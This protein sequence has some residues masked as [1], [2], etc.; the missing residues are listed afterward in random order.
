MG[1]LKDFMDMM[2]RGKEEDSEAGRAAEREASLNRQKEEDLARAQARSVS[3]PIKKE[4]RHSQ[5]E[6]RYILPEEVKKEVE[7]L[8]KAKREAARKKS[9]FGRFF[10]GKK[11]KKP[12]GTKNE[13]K[14]N[15]SSDADSAKNRDVKDIEAE[16]REKAEK[17][18]RLRG[19]ASSEKKRY[20]KETED[21][22]R[23]VNGIPDPERE[24]PAAETPEKDYGVV[25]QEPDFDEAD[26]DKADFDE[27]D[28]DEGDFDEADFNAAPS[29]TEPAAR[30]GERFSFMESV[31]RL[32][33]VREAGLQPSDFPPESPED[34]SQPLSSSQ[35]QET[36]QQPEYLPDP[37]DNPDY[38]RF[39]FA[40]FP[41][42][43]PD[44]VIASALSFAVGF[45][46]FDEENKPV[47]RIITIR[48]LFYQQGDILID[49]FCH[50]IAAPRLIP[51][52]QGIKMYNLQTMKP[53]DNPRDFLLHHMTGLEG[54]N[55]FE[56]PGFTAALSVVRYEL[57]A[58]I[59][60]AK[61][62]FSRSDEENRLIL[63]YISQ[64]C[65]TIDFDEREML[66]YIAMLVP[67]DESFSEALEI[68][69]KQPQDVVI[70][71]V[72][73]FLQMMLSDGVLHEN[74]RELLAELLFL[75]KT[76]GIDLGRIGFG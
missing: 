54:N 41:P 45:I 38:S 14:Q 21:R 59:Y 28:F 35:Q 53:Y 51:F 47:D 18:R 37:L 10:S 46:Y 3:R 30:T 61:A 69:V 56:N 74:E 66:D 43:R 36:P 73:T 7:K 50:D 15:V 65:P 32:N 27:T 22:F 24:N 75:L 39:L 68:I 31:Q 16:K 70:S 44:G 62:D 63:S 19:I 55:G 57:A 11:E 2:E 33:G 52:S 71:F 8:E 76:E 23:A 5:I 17:I 34:F 40:P 49:A 12:A 29:E 1:R 25:P 64:R 42:D 13:A 58:L 20:A 60:V 6:G 9:L 67:D 4:L 48:R 26:F 72:R